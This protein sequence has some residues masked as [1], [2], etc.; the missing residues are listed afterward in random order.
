MVN[1]TVLNGESSASLNDLRKVIKKSVAPGIF[2]AEKP[3]SL[4]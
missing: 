4:L 2:L 3:S 1:K